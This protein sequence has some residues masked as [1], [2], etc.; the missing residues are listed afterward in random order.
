MDEHADGRA[1]WASLLLA[2]GYKVYLVDRPGQG[3]APYEPQ[4]HGAF[5]NAPTYEEISATYT[6]SQSHTGSRNPYAHLHTQWPGSGEIGDP[7]LDQFMAAQGAAFSGSIRVQQLWQSRAALLLDQIGPAIIVTHGDS[8]AFGWLAADARPGLVKALVALEPGGP[9]LDAPGFGPQ[10]VSLSSLRSLGGLPVAVVTGEASAANLTD[11]T[12]VVA[13]RQAGCAVEHL[14]WPRSAF[15][16]T[17][18]T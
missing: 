16:A 1:G 12:T 18:I 14:S 9:A 15:R 7:A 3:R 4:F 10:V 5:R 13:L 17:V 11:P 2:Q 6:T 8:A